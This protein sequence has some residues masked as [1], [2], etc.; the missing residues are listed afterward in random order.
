M[1]NKLDI[2][3]KVLLFDFD[4][5]LVETEI[6]AKKVIDLYFQEKNFPHLSS[7]ADMI[8]GRTWKAATEVMFEHAKGLGVDLDPPAI[9][10]A[11][12][13]MRYQDAFRAGVLMVPG[14]K[15]C[16]PYFKK[17][18][19][20]LGI[21]TGSDRHEVEQILGQHGLLG[22]FDR[23]WGFGDY[24]HSKPDPSPYIQAMTDIQA[25][26]KEVLVFE[27]SKA[28]MESANRAGLPFVQICFEA[29]A[30]E[31]DSRALLTITDWHDLLK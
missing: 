10:Q 8:V 5:T 21:V 6:V 24:E 18:A 7:Y 29:H 1:E 15:D 11:E 4:G 17:N 13:K 16:L 28:G 22:V 20:Y 19:K 23:V 30:K 27:D 2:R 26:S 9:M 25:N 31:V 3:N 12:L 14:F